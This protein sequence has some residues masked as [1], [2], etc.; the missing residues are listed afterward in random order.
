MALD[1][2]STALGYLVVK[3]ICDYHHRGRKVR[4]FPSLLLPELL[5][6]LPLTGAMAAI[7]QVGE[8]AALI[9]GCPS[10][11]DHSKYRAGWDS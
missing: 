6:L 7:G 2:G 1:G 4:S 10:V 3:R 9:G 8:S 11:A 5:E